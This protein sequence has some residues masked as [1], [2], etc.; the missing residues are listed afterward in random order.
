MASD[1]KLRE[2]LKRVL[3]ENQRAQKRLRELEDAS[4]EPIAIVAMG[5]RFPGGVSSPEQLWRLV[6]DEVDAI[7]EFPTDR[8]WDLDNLF[9]PDPECVGKSY[10]R[11]GG[12]LH[13]MAQFD[14]GFFGISPREALAMDPQQRVLLETAWEVFERAGIDPTS[15][16]GTA[17]G[18][19]AGMVY[20][21]FGTRLY[22]VPEEIE[23]YLGTGLAAS[24]VSGRVAYTLGLEGP[25][26]TLDT[27]CSS[28]LVAVHLAAQS[29]R[30]REC[31][32]ALA[33]GVTVMPLP[34]VFVEF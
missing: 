25:A 28:S 34:G 9:D 6:G 16:K 24:I 10:V 14:A 18:V 2:Y 21:D 32:L 22:P 3:V 5:C 8:G 4:R 26:I 12:F 30:Q 15:L 7:S 33:G 19:F 1:E 23:G 27:G 20:Y 17:T 31:S 13:D 11:E 29:L